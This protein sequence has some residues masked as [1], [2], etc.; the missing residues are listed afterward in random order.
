[1]DCSLFEPTDLYQVASIAVDVTIQW[2]V[3]KSL[4]MTNTS[5][6]NLSVGILAISPC[7]YST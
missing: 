6:I 1:M 3:N 2:T 5:G 7:L 4:K